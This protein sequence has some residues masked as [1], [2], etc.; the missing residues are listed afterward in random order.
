MKDIMSSRD[1]GNEGRTL[2]C[3]VTG[4]PDDIY[5][6]HFA[7]DGFSQDW[8]HFH[9]KYEVTLVLEGKVEVISDGKIYVT[10]KPHIRLHQPYVFHTAN[11][12]V[13]H[14]YESFGFYFTERSLAD[15]GIGAEL[16]GMFGQGLSICELEG[17]M[18]ECAKRLAGITL[19]DVDD[20]MRLYVVAGLLDLVR[21]R[22]G[23]IISPPEKREYI[24]DVISYI[25]DHFSERISSAE[26]AK[27]FFI[28]E[29]KLNLDFK[30]VTSDTIHHYCT[31]VKVARAA[32]MIA[33]G[34][35]P[36]AASL[37]CGFIDETHFAKT[38]KSRIGM[39]P[40]QFAKTTESRFRYTNDFRDGEKQG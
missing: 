10:D 3:D 29:Q 40:Y 39:T 27:S 28:S 8:L 26:L 32:A 23:T 34:K 12:E 13:G 21:N 36:L 17:D 9:S 37:E 35:S 18:L 7:S 4:R 19:L 2:F 25:S 15:V 31:T 11:A 14:R 1:N 5:I 20:R 16:Y 30:K 22:C 6:Q 24:C 38:F 33:K